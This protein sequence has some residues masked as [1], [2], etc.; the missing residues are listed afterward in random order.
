[1]I[2][3]ITYTLSGADA[4]QFEINANNGVIIFINQPDF[5]APA[6]A[7]EN[8]VYEIT[9]TADDGLST[10]QNI[11]ITVT[12]GAEAPAFTSVSSITLEENHNGTVL[13]VDAIAFGETDPDVGITYSISGGRDLEDFEI[14]AQ[15]VFLTFCQ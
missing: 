3:N 11:A 9:V 1:L 6:D 12:D 4:S 2:L 14:I 13:D 5:E 15:V 8:N 7:D 10:Q